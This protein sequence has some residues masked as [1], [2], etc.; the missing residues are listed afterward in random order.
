MTD[1]TDGTGPS[2]SEDLIRQARQGYEPSAPASAESAPAA[3]PAS[4]ASAVESSYSRVDVEEPLSRPSDYIRSDYQDPGVAGS[5]DVPAGGV[6]YQAQ[7]PSFFSR[8]G[9][10][11]LVGLIVIGFIAFSAFDKTKAVDDLAVGDCLLMPENEEITSVESTECTEAHELE[12]FHLVTLT[13]SNSTPYPGEDAVFNRIMD[14][15]VNS[16]DGYVGFDYQDSIWFVNAIYPTSESWN[17]QD[18]RA[19]TC[20]LFQP[21][22]GDDPLSLTGSARNSRR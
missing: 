6:T 1:R 16:F 7:R 20:V 15:C 12:V 5:P 9:G 8:F 2:S 11:L 4:P 17:E 21:G 10:L 22:A 19:G 13:D 14:Q 3:P 18:D